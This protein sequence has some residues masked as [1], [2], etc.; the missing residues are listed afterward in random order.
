M[1]VPQ[2]IHSLTDEY[3]QFFTTVNKVAM[4][5]TMMP[6]DGYMHSF[7]RGIYLGV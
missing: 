4:N 3:F 5:M 1:T 2:F 6:F 7:L